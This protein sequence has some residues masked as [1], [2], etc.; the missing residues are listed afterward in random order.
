MTSGA[1][2]I[3]EQPSEAHAAV[4]SS[5]KPAPQGQSSQTARAIAAAP[6]W[7]AGV[8]AVARETT[9]RLRQ[10]QAQL[11]GPTVASSALDARNGFDLCRPNLPIEEALGSRIEGATEAALVSSIST[12][13]A[14][15]D[16]GSSAKSAPWE[17]GSATTP[18]A[19]PGEPQ[20]QGWIMGLSWLLGN[21]GTGTATDQEVAVSYRANVAA[22]GDVAPFQVTARGVAIA[23]F[24]SG[25]QAEQFA[26]QLRAAVV[27]DDFDPSAV[28]PG[29]H[30]DRPALYVGDRLLFTITAA[31][32]E[33]LRRDPDLVA[34]EW[35]NHIREAYGARPF[36]L[37][38][39]QMIMYGLRETGQAIAGLAS[40]Y[41][42]QFHGRLSA[43]GETFSQYA[44]TAAHKTLPFGTFLLV[45]N[46]ESGDRAIVRVNDRGPYIGQRVL[47]LSQ[48]AALCL[49]SFEDG[50]VPVRATLLQVGS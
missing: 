38:D 33:R 46:Q 6:H 12:D 7:Q 25:Q 2:A 49:N 48:K 30:G 8:M 11:L 50:V 45:E 19:A 39:G 5:A 16:P 42:P 26:G 14:G 3:A 27:R 36:S 34:V 37:V 29:R 40:W 43:N 1:V 22:F 9:S 24:F 13:G 31:V 21:P 20:S 10:L 32:T 47:D 23:T 4:S 17:T 18:P 28:R 41:G 35:G 44:M 15:V